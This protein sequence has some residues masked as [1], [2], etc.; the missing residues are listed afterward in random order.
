MLAV[1]LGLDGCH[2]RSELD[3][4]SSLLS[5]DTG[6]REPCAQGWCQPQVDAHSTFSPTPPR[7]KQSGLATG[8]RLEEGAAE[9]RKK[10]LESARGRDWRGTGGSDAELSMELLCRL[11]CDAG[12]GGSLGALL[13]SWGGGRCSPRPCLASVCI[14]VPGVLFCQRPRA[15]PGPPHV[16][17]DSPV[18]TGVVS[19]SSS[20][21]HDPA[22]AASQL[23]GPEA[24]PSREQGLRSCLQRLRFYP[25]G[26]NRKVGLA[27]C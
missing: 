7:G 11:C 19:S 17:A 25:L 21:W 18:Y 24:G 8:R 5:R 4:T 3:R 22:D 10:G 15:A 9:P 14:T 2:G 26:C 27:W 20:E 13:S 16:S 6:N 12:A 23:R 1:C